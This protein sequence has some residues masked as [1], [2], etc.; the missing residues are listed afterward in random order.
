MKA[1]KTKSRVKG[2]STTHQHAE[3]MTV[4]EL[5]YIVAW[6]EGQCPSHLIGSR[7]LDVQD[8]GAI[9]YQI[10]RH[11]LMHVFMST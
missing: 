5:T 11:G 7:L 2:S 8:T 4:E 10:T 6:S 9:R 3:A 1:I